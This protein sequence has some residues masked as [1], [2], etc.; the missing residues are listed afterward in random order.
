MI[1]QNSSYFRRFVFLFLRM[2]HRASKNY[3]DLPFEGCVK[4][5][6]SSDTGT[7][8]D[9]LTLADSNDWNLSGD[10]TIECWFYPT[11]T[12]ANGTY[13]AIISQWENGGGS[14]RNFGILWTTASN[15]TGVYGY[16]QTDAGQY[17]PKIADVNPETFTCRWHHVALVKDGLNTSF[18]DTMNLFI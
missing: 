16:L 4:F 7:D 5:K 10:F 3:S 1:G 14:D 12:P 2:V 15:K 6:G 9:A 8:D 13:G 11:Y 17:D 18:W